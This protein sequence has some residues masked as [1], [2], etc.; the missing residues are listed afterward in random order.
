MLDF[1]QV[2]EIFLA[3]VERADPKERESYLRQACGDDAPLRHRVEAL[4]R[5]HDQADNF[6]EQPAL[7]PAALLSATP[8]HEQD[9]GLRQDTAGTRLGPYQLLQKIGEGG[10]GAVWIAE[11]QEPVRREVAVKVIRAGL[12]SAPVVAR[13]EAERQALAL[14]DHPHIAKVHDGGSTADGRPFLVMEL[15]KGVPITRYCDEQ[16]LTPRQRLELFVPVCEAIQHAHQKGVIHRDVKPS[17][18]LVVPYDG[19]PVVK[20][21]DFGI[22]KAVGPRLTEKSLHT[23]FGTLVG[24]LEYMSPEQAELNNQDIDTRSDVYSLGVLLYELLTGTTPLTAERLARS[25]LLEVL[26]VIREEEPP[27]P[28]TRLS[29]SK[30]ALPS[31]SAQRQ[32]EPAKL[33]KLL[34]GELDWL[35]LK[36][37]EKD[38]NRRYDTANAFARDVAH[39]LNDEPVEACPP[40]A[41]YRLKKF[42]GRNK[43]KVIAAS[44][45]LCSLLAG[46][47][48][49]TMGLVWAVR[50]RDAKEDARKD[51]VASEAEAQ[52]RL[53]QIEKGN[54][55]L[56]SIFTD[57]DIRQVREGTEPIEAVL[58][59]RLVKA[60]GQLEAQA[61]GEPL[62]VADLQEHL[63]KTLLSLSHPRDAIP[64]FVK[65]RE[66]RTARLGADHPDTLSSMGHLAAAYLDDGKLDLAL[67]LLK[68]T[69]KLMKAK[70]G[71]DHTNTLSSMDYLA[72]A[73][74]DAGKLDLALPLFEESLKLSK[75]KRGV[76]HP[77]TLASMSNLALGYRS[78]GKL[79]LALPLFEESLKLSKVKR[80][81]DHPETLVSMNNL[82]LG[83]YSAGKLDLALPLLEETLKL[84]KVKLGAEHA[85]TLSCMG[86]LAQGYAD[87]GKRDLALPLF[88]ET[89]KRMKARRGADHPQRLKTMNNLAIA[90]A[91]ARKLDLA[92]P[93][94]EETLKLMKARRGRDHPDTLACMGNLAAVYLSAGKP[95]L[96]LPHFQEAVAGVEKQRFQHPHAVSIVTNLIA[97]LERL[98]QFDQAETWLRKRLALI[99]E[100]AGADSVAYATALGELASFLVQRQKWAE[101]EPVLREDL[102]IR[103][104]KKPEAWGTFEL[105]SVLGGALLHRKKYADAEPLLLAGYE[106]LRQRADKIPPQLKDQKLQN[107]LERLVQLYV[108][109]G[110]SDEAAK[111][112]KKR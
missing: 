66:T 80:G 23:E 32:T 42:I 71:A 53:A 50:E 64:L 17:N 82:A 27:R 21:I 38:R 70:I 63:G 78:A 90:Y 74:V 1:K 107:A 41:A 51:A 5:R 46:M 59:R 45:V 57:L 103:K 77:E 79:D 56:T 62:M 30:E 55:I 26:R 106:G 104:K 65:A 29:D 25:P 16:R 96:A 47:I 24:T 35:V 36:A 67:P 89:L 10:M 99:K 15:V 101:A 111:W 85:N 28:S 93:L 40:S 72:K 33:C 43:G 105:M 3:A 8:P 48:G 22:A 7:D 94:F 9:T 13:F 14:M 49:T 102:A 31:I 91:R 69:V 100:Q 68:E 110:K 76:D 2:R 4:L 75:V 12:D 83:Y 92:L 112:R 98:Q 60:A 87:T 81:A 86:N 73:Y 11:Q 54:E 37:L 6:L 20:V 34:R 39:F 52:K 109:W 61:V 108:A 84:M 58:A 97:C 88:E 95:D 19:R 18:V 44:V